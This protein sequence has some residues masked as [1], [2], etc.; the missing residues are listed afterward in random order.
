MPPKKIYRKSKKSG[1][2]SAIATK[3]YVKR[4]FKKNIEAKWGWLEYNNTI[5]DTGY[6]GDLTVIAPGTGVNARIGDAISPV[7][8]KLDICALKADDTNRLRFILFQWHPNDAADVPQLAEILLYTNGYQTQA[9]LDPDRRTQ[10][11]V[12]KDF[13]M[14]FGTGSPYL[15]HKRIKIRPKQKITYNGTGNTGR[16]HVYLLIVSDSGVTTH[17]SVTYTSMFSYTDA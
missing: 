9:P 15:K 4:M 7:S 12:Y 1:K 2:R 13:L 11:T 17:P 6:I 14:V 8:I 16:N 5:D 3:K 10:Y